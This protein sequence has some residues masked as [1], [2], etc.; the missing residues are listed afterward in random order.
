MFKGLSAF[1][2]SPLRDGQLDEAA[3]VGLVTRLTDARVDSI[4]ALGSTG[5]YAYLDREERAWIAR[6]AVA[7]AD[8][9]PVM[10]GIGALRTRDVLRHAED[11]QRA[12]ASAVLLAPVSY[13]PL[14]AEE[15]FRLYAAVSRHLSV[16]LCVYDNP[17]TT[18]FEFSDDLHAR[19]AALPHVASIKLPGSVF[20]SPL[21][22]QRIARLR[23]RIPAHVSLGVSG[24][25]AAVAGFRAGCDV[26]YSVI[27][28]L[29][30][31]L[32]L[33]LTRAA[34]AGDWESAQH[35][36]D[37]LAP[38]WALFNQHGGSVRVMAAAAELMELAHPPSLPAP[39][40]P[41]EGEARA[42]VAAVLQSLGLLA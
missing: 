42:A 1:P 13:Q 27:G 40:V 22:G 20:E 4:G 2:L 35:A 23:A 14:N 31:D 26:W 41:V 36:S 25:R 15:V 6:T 28:G 10:V 12:G 3:F 11:A 33:A 38:L 18:R 19:I 32:A 5:S 16:P 7:H 9:I 21:A 17:G 34:Q 37:R 24:D 39:L 30:P 29:F 8:G